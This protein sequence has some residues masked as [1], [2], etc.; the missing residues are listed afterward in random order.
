MKCRSIGIERGK[1]QSTEDAE[2]SYTE[3]AMV[4]AAAQIITER[5]LKET[6][7]P[8]EPRAPKSLE[9]ENA[10]IKRE[11][12][13]L[14]NQ[15][16]QYK[17]NADGQMRNGQGPMRQAPM[18]G[19]GNFRGQNG[20]YNRA[21][22]GNGGQQRIQE[23]RIQ[24][25]PPVQTFY[26]KAVGTDPDVE[27]VDRARCRFAKVRVNVD[28]EKTPIWKRADLTENKIAQEVTASAEGVQTRSQR[29]QR[30]ETEV[31]G[32]YDGGTRSRAGHGGDKRIQPQEAKRNRDGGDRRVILSETDQRR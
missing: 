3:R 26:M 4:A 28:M 9:N 6:K 7:R 8:H 27:G 2:S 11:L 14:K 24:E 10:E 19:R 17:R 23:Q 5:E 31:G 1:E 16:N 32:N 15:F 12:T 13:D 20:G 30:K 25:N 21:P 18:R 22:W 29:P